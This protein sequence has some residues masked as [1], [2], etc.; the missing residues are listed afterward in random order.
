MQS[1]QKNTVVKAAGF[2]MMTMVISRILGYLRDV[3]IYNQFGQNRITDA[4]NAA[5]SV[6]DFIYMILV[7]GALSSAFIP[8]FSS[9]IA[10]DREK[11]GWEVASIVFNWIMLFLLV[12]ITIGYIFT[13]QLINILVPGFGSEAKEMTIHLTRIMFLQVVFLSL[14]G[15]SMG[16]LNSYKHFTSPAMGSVIYN[17]GIIVGGLLLAAPIEAIWPGYGIAGFSIGVVIGA[18]LNF[19]IQLP[20]L[21]KVGLRYHFSFNFRH[22]GVRKLIFLLIPVLIGLSASQINLFVNQNLAST[23]SEGMVAALR[24]GQRIMQLP[25][26]VFAIAIAV[27]VF[28]TLTA[29]VARREISEFKS[30]VS[31]GIRAVVFVTL[32]AAVGIAV[33]RIPIIRFM[34]EFKGGEF[35]SAS[36][37]ATSEALLFYCI[38]LV[39]YSAIHVLSRTFY[40]L[41]NTITPVVAAVLSIVVNIV[42]SIILLGPMAQG[43]LALAY[44]LAGIFNMLLLLWLFKRKMGQIGGKVM[45]R[46]FTK[47]GVAAVLM[48]VV[49]TTLSLLCEK[50]LDMTNKFIQVFQLIVTIGVGGAV[51]FLIT[52]MWKMEES[53]MVMSIFRKRF[54]RHRQVEGGN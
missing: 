50:N 4:Y 3:F 42:F 24:T 18:A 15:I 22:P 36:T 16:I 6:P 47:M 5:F 45:L 31:L 54:G 49:V 20:A 27:A 10:T 29:H 19:L 25:I 40:S 13:P 51:Y 46:S 53:K 52:Y 1:K 17:L 32:P 34:F 30:A 37:F 38:G 14:S 39:A 21:K 48:A 2:I 26:G 8:I 7:G 41:Q 28:P 35:T 9:Y 23:L 33:L 12:A 11:E 44:S 43:G